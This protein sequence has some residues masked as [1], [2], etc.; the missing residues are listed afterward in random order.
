MTFDKKENELISKTYFKVNKFYK[1]VADE[2]KKTAFKAD[3]YSSEFLNFLPK[4]LRVVKES[5]SDV[6]VLDEALE[7][8]RKVGFEIMARLPT[9]KS[10]KDLSEWMV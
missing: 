1:E 6:N 3:V 10:I 4:L 7:V 2:N 9:L 8:G 5:I